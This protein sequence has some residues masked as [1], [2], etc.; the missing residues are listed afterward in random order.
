MPLLPS[1]SETDALGI[2][3]AV[4]NLARA[5]FFGTGA[6]ESLLVHVEVKRPAVGSASIGD[7][8]YAPWLFAGVPAQY[9]RIDYERCT[10]LISRSPSRDARLLPN[11]FTL[12]FVDRDGAGAVPGQYMPPRNELLHAVL[13]EIHGTWRGN[14]F[15]VRHSAVGGLEDVRADEKATLDW[16]VNIFQRMSALPNLTVTTY[17]VNN[18]VHVDVSPVK[19]SVDYYRP[20]DLNLAGD[21]LMAIVKGHKKKDD[22]F[23]A[24]LISSG[25][26]YCQ[27]NFPVAAS[28]SI[29]LIS[30]NIKALNTRRTLRGEV[31]YTKELPSSVDGINANSMSSGVASADAACIDSEASV[32]GGSYSLAFAK[33]RDDFMPTR[34]SSLGTGSLFTYK[35]VGCPMSTETEPSRSRRGSLRG[36]RGVVFGEIKAVDDERLITVILKSPDRASCRALDFFL[37]QV[38]VLQEIIVEDEL[39]SDG[40]AVDTWFGVMNGLPILDARCVQTFEV[41]IFPTSDDDFRCLIEALYVGKCVEIVTKLQRVDVEDSR[42]LTTERSY[43]LIGIDVCGMDR[44]DIPRKG[45]DYVCDARASEYQL[46]ILCNKSTPLPLK[47]VLLLSNSPLIPSLLLTMKIA[48]LSVSMPLIRKTARMTTG[49]R[50][51]RRPVDIK[52]RDRGSESTDGH[53]ISANAVT[54]PKESVSCTRR[55]ARMSTGGRPPRRPVAAESLLGI[56]V[57]ASLSDEDVQPRSS[58]VEHFPSADSLMSVEEGARIPPFSCVKPQERAREDVRLLIGSNADFKWL[59]NS[60]IPPG[61]PRDHGTSPDRSRSSS[62]SSGFRIPTA[63]R[64]RRLRHLSD[65]SEPG[66]ESP[67]GTEDTQSTPLRR[68]SRAGAGGRAPKPIIESSIS[69]SDSSASDDEDSLAGFIV[70]D[71]ARGCVRVNRDVSSD[72]DYDP[73]QRRSNSP[74][75][76]FLDSTSDSTSDRGTSGLSVNALKRRFSPSLSPPRKTLKL[77]HRGA[78]HPLLLVFLYITFCI[79]VGFQ[80]YSDY[81]SL[82]ATPLVSTKMRIKESPHLHLCGNVYNKDFAATRD[83]SDGDAVSIFTFKDCERLIPPTE[84]SKGHLSTFTTWVFGEVAD[85]RSTNVSCRVRKY[86]KEQLEVLRDILS[87]DLAE[88]GG[89][90]MSSWTAPPVPLS[91]FHADS[92]CVLI[93]H[94]D[95]SLRAGCRLELRVDFHRRDVEVNQVCGV[96]RSYEMRTWRYESLGQSDIPAPGPDYQCDLDVSGCR[97]RGEPGPVFGDER[98]AKRIAKRMEQAVALNYPCWWICND[99]PDFKQET[100]M[101]GYIIGEVIAMFPAALRMLIL[102]EV[103]RR[104]QQSYEA[105]CA[106]LALAVASNNSFKVDMCETGKD[107]KHGTTFKISVPNT[108]GGPAPVGYTVLLQVSVDGLWTPDAKTFSRAL[109][110]PKDFFSYGLYQEDFVPTR[111][112][113]RDGGD[114][115]SFKSCCEPEIAASKRKRGHVKVYEPLLFG[116]V[117]VVHDLTD[118]RGVIVRLICPDGVSCA[119]K[120]LYQRQLDG[121]NDILASDDQEIGGKTRESWFNPSYHGQLLHLEKGCFYVVVLADSDHSL[122]LLRS[123]TTMNENFLVYSRFTRLDTVNVGTGETMRFIELSKTYGLVGWEWEDLDDFDLPSVGD[124]Y[125]CDVANLYAQPRNATGVV[126]STGFQVGDGRFQ[127]MIIYVGTCFAG[128]AGVSALGWA[129]EVRKPRQNGQNSE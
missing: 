100:S 93:T 7:V 17:G 113:T 105:Q 38:S 128:A 50:P 16:I 29:S 10:T 30:P 44:E 71:D 104:P 123:C 19:G 65:D 67:E 88:L 52:E 35:K 69:D 73:T 2:Q 68:T 59:P 98:R 57:V 63:R 45:V 74:R 62:V 22:T 8:V 89:S 101:F 85:F 99:V 11:A 117:D 94:S 24:P 37:R 27:S 25:G 115:F 3:E 12:F 84:F 86:Y 13:G 111:D 1:T 58:N 23:G 32:R 77:D 90:V 119:V 83:C 95:M 46:R 118:R 120:E 53:R 51:P 43:T 102:H 92:F 126:E 79:A 14:I 114:F 21:M 103:R 122:R 4:N 80:F 110:D 20:S 124:N 18:A 54:S 34:D 109:D 75:Y 70:A 41:Q 76:P 108:F 39:E 116:T 40:F 49:S 96:E 82:T 28:C 36:Y 9:H 42:T 31:L 55:T 60:P 15:A 5:L 112:C 127:Q 6:Q 47:T 129:L 97:I 48:Y 91:S 107:R 106:N 33:Y 121:L 125:V 72:S 26:T 61:D 87:I 81:R 64:T 78:D 56:A 66:N